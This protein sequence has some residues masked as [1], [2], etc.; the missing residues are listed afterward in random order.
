MEA[1]KLTLGDLVGSD[2]KESSNNVGRLVRTRIKTGGD[3]LL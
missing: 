1:H 3:L 2:I